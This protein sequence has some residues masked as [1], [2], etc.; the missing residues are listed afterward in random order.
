M[1]LLLPS[2]PVAPGGA[3]AGGVAPGLTAP[4]NTAER[5]GPAGMRLQDGRPGAGPGGA[6]R[7]GCL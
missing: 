4:S 3:G 5:R 6:G 7:A 2:L 1:R